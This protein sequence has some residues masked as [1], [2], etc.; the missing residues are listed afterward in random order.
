VKVIIEEIWLREYEAD[1]DDP[2]E[3]AD[4]A[5][6]ESP[7]IAV[8]EKSFNFDHSHLIKV[9]EPGGTEPVLEDVII[10]DLFTEE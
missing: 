10:E 6:A 4:A 8:V 7:D 2:E 1:T 5:I 9:F 3:A